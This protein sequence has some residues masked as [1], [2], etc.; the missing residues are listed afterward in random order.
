MAIKVYKKKI[1]IIC[2]VGLIASII[3]LY[4]FF[5]PIYLVTID[6]IK[7]TNKL[8]R[9]FLA[10]INVGTSIE[11]VKEKLGTPKTYFQRPD[12]VTQLGYGFE[13]LGIMI[14]SKDGKKVD[15]LLLIL[16]SLEKSYPL[17]PLI[18]S[19]YKFT[20]G[21]MQFKDLNRQLK[22]FKIELS[23]KGGIIYIDDYFGNSG[24]Y[25]NYRFA[26]YMG[27][28]CGFDRTT[29]WSVEDFKTL[30]GSFLNEII[31]YVF[32]TNDSKELN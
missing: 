16:N 15:A 12:G 27:Y 18:G 29:D 31:N 30:K 32:I 19:S 28:G 23:S 10:S 11:Y 9:D 3:S 17:Y 20:L 26:N 21:K 6:N 24:E 25:Y 22:D 1:V 14:Q 5:N 2:I 13:N 8:P 4:L 7:I